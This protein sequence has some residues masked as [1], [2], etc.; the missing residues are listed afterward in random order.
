M[1]LAVWWLGVRRLKERLPAVGHAPGASVDGLGICSLAVMESALRLSHKVSGPSVAALRDF[2]TDSARLTAVSDVRV[3]RR[4]FSSGIH[5]PAI[6]RDRTRSGV[7][8]TLARRAHPSAGA[9][10][11]PAPVRSGAEEL[12][13]CPGCL[14]RFAAAPGGEP[15]LGGCDAG[16]PHVLEAR[17]E[18]TSRTVP[19]EHVPAVV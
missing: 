18:G 5:D 17:W 1:I 8:D 12:L 14:L 7:G 16:A 4:P 6:P 19:G 2:T 10:T 3:A 11:G 9:T 13:D 15:K